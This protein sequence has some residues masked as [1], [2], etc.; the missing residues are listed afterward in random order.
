MWRAGCGRSNVWIAE[1]NSSAS[2]LRLSQLRR[3]QELPGAE[4]PFERLVNL[5]R[6][7][8]YAATAI[9]APF[10]VPAEYLPMGRHVALLRLAATLPLEG[11][12]PFAK[13][14]DLVHAL[15]PSSPPRGRKKYRV[16]DDEWREAGVTIRSTLWIDPRGGAPMTAAC[17]TLL[18]AVRRPLWPWTRARKGVIAEAFPAAQL[19]RWELDRAGYNGETDQARKTRR[20][21]LAAL[22]QRLHLPPRLEA[23][24]KS[25]ADALDAVL[26]AFAAIAVTRGK[27]ASR[28][29]ASAHAEGWIAV[30]S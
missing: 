8:D 12:R 14:R 5:L 9:D 7:G 4:L 27:L 24:M 30:H 10:S 28:P 29:G 21:M 22:R 16:T 11:N 17:L 3:V 1:V 2:G 26:C 15:D 19:A 20:T 13:G 18:A 6:K 25:S 23:Q